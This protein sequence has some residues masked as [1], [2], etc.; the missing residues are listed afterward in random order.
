M[1]FCSVAVR[2]AEELTGKSIVPA[3]TATFSD[4]DNAYVLKAYAAGI[5]SG[6]GENTFSP[7]ATL[8]RQQMAT[9]IYRTLQYV[10][11]NSDIKYTTYESKLSDYADNLQIAGWAREP[12]AFMNALDLI[13]GTTD[14]TI[15]P[16]AQCTIE[17]ALTVASRSIYADHIGWYQ[18][19]SYAE[20]KNLIIGN[21]NERYWFSANYGPVSLM[22]L[23]HDKRIWVTGRRIK[24]DYSYLTTA[25]PY[26]GQV[27]FV[28]AEWLRPI[29]E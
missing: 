18:V 26:T 29:R 7:Y 23:I 19:K 17:Q 6:T 24:G 22:N 25:D 11:A 9:F 12:L 14:T 4:T 28:L 20:N 1:Q 21:N 3:P 8:D 10:K 27:F 2:L 13:K 5:T 16:S 15:S